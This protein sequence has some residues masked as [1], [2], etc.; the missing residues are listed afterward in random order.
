MTRS[1]QSAKQAGARFEQTIAT[2]LADRLQDDRIERR[3]KNGNKDRGDLTGIRTLTGARVVAELKD[4]AGTVHVK[5]WLDQ[6]AV[7]AGNDDAP[8]GVVIFKRRGIS[9]PMQQGV[10]MTVEDLAYLLTGGIGWQER[11]THSFQEK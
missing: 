9:D 4:Y 11:E 1:R 8:I 10:L 6:A 3:T 5:E 7:E 2:A